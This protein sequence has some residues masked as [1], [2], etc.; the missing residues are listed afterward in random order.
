M[1]LLFMHYKKWGYIGFS[2]WEHIVVHEVVSLQFFSCHNLNQSLWLTFNK[3]LC[4]ENVGGGPDGLQ[5]NK[6]NIQI[7]QEMYAFLLRL[8]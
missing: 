8:G 6:Y 5:W 4:P 3:K 2:P 1:T 7:A